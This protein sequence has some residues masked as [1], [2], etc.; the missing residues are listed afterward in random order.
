MRLIRILFF[1]WLAVSA[2]W[3]QSAR[4]GRVEIRGVTGIASFIDESYQNHFVGGGSAHFYL[5]DRLSVGPELLYMRRDSTDSDVTATA[6]FAWDFLG[7]PRVQPY[8]AGS[9]GVLRNFAPRFSVSSWTYGAGIGAKIA[10][11]K[12]LYLVPDFRIGLE[13]I[14]RAT[15]G[16]SYVVGQ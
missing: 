7:G 13:P 4:R 6:Q 1:G 15:V 2:V 10:L 9:V 12:R 8:A 3:A 16:V 14:F 11:T 5:T